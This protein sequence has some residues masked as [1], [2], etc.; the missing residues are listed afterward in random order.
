MTTVPERSQRS[1]RDPYLPFRRTLLP[2][3]RIRELSRR[4][5]ARVVRDT[6]LCWAIIVAA[7][8]AAAW[9]DAWWAIALAIVVVGNRYYSLFIIGHDGLH[10]RLFD[11]ARANDLFAD[12]FTLA[13]IGA[14]TRINN[15][16]HLK[17]H[18]YLATE[19]DPDRHKHGCFNKATRP[20]LFSYLVSLTSV[21]RSVRHVFFSRGDTAAEE[22][23][24]RPRYRLRDL[25]LLLAVQAVLLVTLTLLFGWW[26][27]LLLWWIPVFLLAFLADNFRTFVEHSQPRGDAAADQHRLV[28]NEPPWIEAQLFAPMNMHYHAAHHLWP[29]IPY[30]NLPAANAEL[31]KSP[32]ADQL[33]WRGSYLGY[34]WTYFRALPLEECRPAPVRA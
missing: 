20:A 8:A 3:E 19:A 24:P 23:E 2:P 28:T 18:R 5:P 11:S 4:R 32:D 17:H 31:R 6:L 27:Y 1:E 7:W 30:Y 12:I 14:I 29:S 26:G 22:T 16:N 13:P 33:T 34:L 25:A 21:V 10:R 15:R 9:I